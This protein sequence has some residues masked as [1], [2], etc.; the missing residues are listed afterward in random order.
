[1]VMLHYCRLVIIIL[2]HLILQML[3][4]SLLLL[5]L[6]GLCLRAFRRLH[7][8]LVF[9]VLLVDVAA[10]VAE[11]LVQHHI[12]INLGLGLSMSS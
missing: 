7:P 4:H 2:S 3:I 11:L 1:M 8:K 12:R 10:R 6:T 9:I 5:F